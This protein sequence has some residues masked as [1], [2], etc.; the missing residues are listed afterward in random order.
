MKEFATHFLFPPLREALNSK[1]V[2]GARFPLSPG[3]RLSAN[4]RQ[5]KNVF[6]PARAFFGL[7]LRVLFSWGT[8]RLPSSHRM[9]ARV[10]RIVWMGELNCSRRAQ[11]RTYRSRP[12]LF[13]PF[14]RAGELEGIKD[15]LLRR[16]SGSLWLSSDNLRKFG[17]S[18]VL[19]GMDGNAAY[20]PRAPLRLQR[21]VGRE[22]LKDMRRPPWGNIGELFFATPRMASD[23]PTLPAGI[24]TARW[25]P[26]RLTLPR[27][28][29]GRPPSEPSGDEELP[30]L[31]GAA[32]RAH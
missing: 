28:P 21:P 7:L 4:I 19:V 15:V 27:A 24:A 20:F 1:A 2:R 5:V 10:L 14:E 6:S 26:F 29:G 12:H 11:R 16:M 9:L 25:R 17:V 13:I 32:S 31:R 30:E 22:Y 8:G 18:R 3:T 23:A